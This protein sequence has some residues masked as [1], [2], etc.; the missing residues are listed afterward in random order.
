MFI[1][2]GMLAVVASDLL[3]LLEHRNFGGFHQNNMTVDFLTGLYVYT[4]IT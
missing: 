1:L 3:T 4:Y 2:L